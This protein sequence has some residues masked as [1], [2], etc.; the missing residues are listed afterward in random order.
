MAEQ[1]QETLL[2][3]RIDPV[4]RFGTTR[5]SLRMKKVTN[6][7]LTQGTQVVRVGAMGQ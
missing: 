3:H 4:G 7:L 1:V 5:G 2:R 6:A